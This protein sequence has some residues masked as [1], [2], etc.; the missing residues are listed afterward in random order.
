MTHS[1]MPSGRACVVI[2]ALLAL[3]LLIPQVRTK[4]GDTSKDEQK[5]TPLFDGKTL[6][7][8]SVSRIE[9]DKKAEIK[10][11]CIIVGRDDLASGVK[12]DKPF[13]KSNYE[14]MYQAKRVKGYDFFGTITFPV[15]ESHCSFVAG[16]WSGSVI[17][18]S[19]INGYDASE[20]ETSAFYE[21][22]DKQWYQFRVRVSDDR[23]T[24]WCYPVD[25]DGKIIEA[26]K[27]D[28]KA[29][30]A[31]REEVEKPKADLALKD[32]RVSTRLEVTFFQPL[33][34]STWN[35]EGHL[36]DIKYRELTPEEIEEIQQL[37]DRPL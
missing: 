23:I 24:V 14:I 8:W 2:L 13:P 31:G 29:A 3:L 10:D 26:D 27:D 32:K 28:P 15:K 4:A 36:R 35:T 1:I 11:G 22:K 30:A 19:S 16:G 6:D 37:P 18:L 17:G 21:F 33:G 7:G 5:W 25:E 34:I 9:A 20:N 12:Y